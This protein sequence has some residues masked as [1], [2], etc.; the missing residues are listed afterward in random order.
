MRKAS[1]IKGLLTLFIASVASSSFA[2]SVLEEITIIGDALAQKELAGSGAVIESEQLRLEVATDINQILKT[3][4]G[5]YIR[6]EEGFGLRPNIGI[7]GATAERSARILLLEDGVPIAPAPYAAPAAYYF[8]TLARM[9]SVE[10]LKGVSMLTHGPQSTGG[11][12]NLI[13]TPL[14][15]ETGGSLRASLASFGSSDTTVSYGIAGNELSALVEATQRHSDGFKSLDGDGSDTGFDIADY[16]VKVGWMGD[17][18]QLL[19]KAQYSAETSN[20]TYTGLS[21]RDFDANANR[22]YGMTA[23][24]QM[25][26][27]HASMSLRH[28]WQISD[29]VELSSEWYRNDFARDWYK[30][31][32]GATWIDQ[33]NAGDDFAA[34]ILHGDA[35]VA[36]LYYKHN[37]REYLA[38]GVRLAIS[39]LTDQHTIELSSRWHDDR[40][41]RWQPSDIYDQVN[42]ELIFQE[43]VSPSGSNN[44]LE[45]ATA[46]ALALT[47]AWQVNDRLRLDLALRRETVKSFS[48]RFSDMARDQLSDSRRNR[49]Q[50][51]L[52]GVGAFYELTPSIAL[53]AGIHK[54]FSP[55]GAGAK[56]DEKPELSVNWEMG[57]RY[58]GVV[59]ADV[60]VFRSDFDNKA[61]ICSV[62]SPCSNGAEQGAFITGEAVIQGVEL[63]LSGEY[64]LGFASV[65][66]AVSFTQTDAEITSARGLSGVQNGDHL[67]AVP[68]TMAAIRTGL[69]F[70]TG[71]EFLA[72]A[73]FTDAL[74]V[75]AGCNRDNDALSQTD[76]YWS[77][78][79]AL[80]H[81]LSDS[82]SGFVKL[83]NATD[84]RAIVSRQPDGARPNKPQSLIAGFEWR[85]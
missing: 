16:L 42:G 23:L 24:D 27:H 21:D 68:K 81:E 17:T 10:V 20:E 54:G 4:P 13:S 53:L 69:V 59:D 25:D 15:T 31:G 29:N 30:L 70:A 84:E 52:P 82:L 74:C 1:I 43:T 75:K 8:P 22:R 26:N 39:W 40:V 32:N 41:D 77:V 49:T 35:D 67:A 78:D 9:S 79:L 11:A 72:T 60:I 45:G 58:S 46:Q 71:T 50:V 5:V 6:E 63:S 37:N 14:P 73:K 2:N 28:F 56:P 80:H 19:L 83:E 7:R 76:S 47:D 55:L 48:N 65:P 51:T 61:E 36:G 12:L 3:V 33:A 38:E 64:E 18:Q 85:F 44:R 34:A 66:V 62:A 57:V